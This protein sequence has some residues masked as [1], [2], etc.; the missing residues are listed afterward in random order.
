MGNRKKST[1]KIVG[2]FLFILVIV[3]VGVLMHFK[4]YNIMYNYMEEQV[5]SQ[6]ESYAGIYSTKLDMEL[7]K[8][9]SIAAYIEWEELDEE[10]L[11]RIK[12]ALEET[13]EG[14]SYGILGVGDVAVYGEKLEFADFAGIQ[15]SFRGNSAVCYDKEKGL[16]LTTPVFHGK[17]IKYVLYKL[18]D[19]QLI[20]VNASINCFGGDEKILITSKSGQ[21]IYAFEDSEYKAVFEGKKGEEAFDVIKD[22]MELSVSAATHTKEHFYFV[23]EIEKTDFYLV[24][25]VPK[26]VIEEGI[27][28]IFFLIYWVF[29][30]LLVLFGIVVFYFFGAQEKARES[31][32]LRAAKEIAEMANRAKNDFL[33]N[34]SHEIRTPINAISGMN[35]MI[36]RESTDENITKYALNIK[37]AGQTLLALINDILDFAKIEAGKMELVEDNYQ[38]DAVLSDVLYMIKDRVNKKNLTLEVDVDEKVPNSLFGDSMKVHQIIL[39]LLT[40]AVKYTERGKVSLHVG[41]VLQ[42]DGSALLKIAVSDTGIGIKQE[43]M[44]KLFENFERLN[45]KNNRHIQGTGLGLAITERLLKQMDGQIT[46]ESTYGKG[47]TFTITLSQKITADEPIGDFNNKYKRGRTD[48]IAYHESF[49]APDAHILVVDDNEINLA[50]VEGLL[51]KTLINV[52]LTQSGAECLSLMKKQHFDVIFL[53]HMMPEMDGIETLKQAKVMKESLCIDTPVIALTANAMVGVRDMYLKEGFHDYMSKPIEGKALEE[54][55]LKYLPDS[56]ILLAENTPEEEQCKQ[57]KLNKEQKQSDSETFLNIPLG[58]K[59]CGDSIEIYQKMLTMFCELKKDKKEQLEESFAKEDY[60]DYIISIHALKS[61]SLSIGGK[62]LSSAAE[63]SEKAGKNGDFDFVKANH[64][65][66]MNLYDR[67]VQQAK[68]YLSNLS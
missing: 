37:Y 53:D 27:S 18:L 36:L 15:D 61:S 9:R 33:A 54:M 66:V 65:Y 42:E 57:E 55:L 3:G 30:L 58:M 21:P 62:E 38:L 68:E 31:E 16:L 63:K 34:M 43:D 39:N 10:S 44:N 47:S 45:I 52:V 41:S 22:K 17:N 60:N 6:A 48:V 67:T 40:N 59:Y 46:V 2:V 5:A 35:E 26:E 12:K 24:G 19:T 7:Q 25:V 29:G 49:T 13:Q 64:D 56:K 11:A 14:V 50:V 28:D 4:L 23:S 8:L 32:Q 1:Q 20:D 51:K